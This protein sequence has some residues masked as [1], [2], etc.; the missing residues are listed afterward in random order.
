MKILRLKSLFF[1][2]ELSLIITN[3]STY[4]PNDN[5]IFSGVFL[6]LSSREFGIKQ[7]NDKIQV[8]YKNQTIIRTEYKDHDISLCDIGFAILTAPKYF[9]TRVKDLKNSWLRHLCRTGGE[10]QFSSNYVLIS[11]EEH[12]DI[13]TMIPNCEENYLNLCCKTLASYKW[14]VKNWPKKKWY[15][16]LDDDTFVILSNLID[17]LSSFNSNDNILIGGQIYLTLEDSLAN[18]VTGR[19]NTLHWKYHGEVIKGIRGGAGYLMSNSLANLFIKNGQRYL[20]ICNDG[21]SKFKTFEDVSLSLLITELVGQK[22]IKHIPG[23]HFHNPEIS[24]RNGFDKRGFRP[25]TFHMMHDTSRMEFFDYL[26]NG[27]MRPP[28]YS[29]NHSSTNMCISEFDLSIS[30]KYWDPVYFG[31]LSS[32]SSK[33]LGKNAVYKSN[34]KSEHIY[35]YNSNKNKVESLNNLNVSKVKPVQKSTIEMSYP[36]YSQLSNMQVT[37]V[38]KFDEHLNNTNIPLQFKYNSLEIEHPCKNLI[39]E[40]S[41]KL[42][43]YYKQVFTGIKEVLFVGFP[44]HPNR[45]DSAIFTGALIL[46]EY[47][48][49]KIIKVVHLLNEYNVNEILNS[50]SYKTEERAIIF[51]GGGNFGDLYSHHHEL[52]HIV[53]ND[54]IDYK[55]IMFPQT[56]FFKNEINKVATK[57]NFV[58]HKGEIFLAARDG[59]SLKIMTEMF[60]DVKHIKLELLPDMAFLIGDQRKRRGIPSLDI[61]VHAR[62]DNEAPDLMFNNTLVKMS[63]IKIESVKKVIKDSIEIE[64]NSGKGKHLSKGNILIKNKEWIDYLTILIDDWLDSDANYNNLISSDYIEKSISRTL[65][66]MAFLSRAN[67]VITNRLHGHILLTLLGVSHIVMGDSFGKLTN[68]RE[69]WTASCPLSSWHDEFSDALVSASKELYQ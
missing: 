35:I 43:S 61:L 42:K 64:N 21:G 14:M 62:V 40:Y 49:I 58:N 30:S 45:G 26:L 15:M 69:T 5:K 47:L 46:L 18:S 13:P 41:N 60:N 66:G 28:T 37:N 67:F 39:E 56:V 11:S 59:H 12:T 65:D 8:G 25:I 23:F 57:K 36:E 16:K 24:Y 48:K 7:N 22:S 52:R 4:I 3:S 63:K 33:I 2:L 6:Q 34:S 55:I 44:D 20:D 50:F 32:N 17:E 68:F 31:P 51:H 9:N 19:S 54:F 29:C 53:L 27:S 10:Q 38:F 1:F